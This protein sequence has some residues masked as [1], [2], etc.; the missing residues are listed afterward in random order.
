MNEVRPR[1]RVLLLP[2]L[3]LLAGAVI[4]LFSGALIGIDLYHGII[5]RSGTEKLDTP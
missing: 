2:A 3:A 5:D 1:K 4:A